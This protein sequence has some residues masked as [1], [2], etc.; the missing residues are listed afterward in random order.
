M[1]AFG[2]VPAELGSMSEALER[3]AVAFGGV[4]G[5]AVRPDASSFGD[6]RLV[7]ALADAAAWLDASCQDA[8]GAVSQL[9]RECADAAFAYDTTDT[10]VVHQGREFR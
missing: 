3:V 9:G 1:V 5:G 2:V 8:R 4:S 10:T 7:T 6:A